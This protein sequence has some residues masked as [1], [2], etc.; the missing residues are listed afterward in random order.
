MLIR[1]NSIST[2]NLAKVIS[3][4]LVVVTFSCEDADYDLDNPFDPINIDL[5]PPALFFIHLRSIQI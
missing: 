2:F 4:C 3:L 5:D 1:Y